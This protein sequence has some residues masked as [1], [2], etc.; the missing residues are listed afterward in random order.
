M[1][2]EAAEGR[3]IN[4]WLVVGNDLQ[5][6]TFQ[7]PEFV[8]ELDGERTRFSAIDEGDWV[9]IV[10]TSGKVERVARI[11]RVRSDLHRT[12]LYFDK[13]AKV[14]TAASLADLS[15]SPPASGAVSRLP[16]ASFTAA[17]PK[18]GIS[19]VHDVPLLQH[20]AYIRELLQLAVIDDLLG[21]AN[22]PHER[23]LD[24]GVRDRYLVGKLAPQERADGGV[25]GL[26]GPLAE[27][28]A[29]DEPDDLEV[30]T[31]RHVPG[32]EFDGT[33]GRVDAEAEASDEIDATNNQ[34]LVPSS[35]G[36]T[37][38]VDGDVKSIVVEARWGRYV[39]SYD[40]GLTKTINRKV[41][42]EDGNVTRTEQTEVALKVWQRE[43]RGGTLTID[44]VTGVVTHRAP[45]SEQ[46]EVRVQGAVRAK[47]ANGDRLVTLFLVNAQIDPPDNKD[48]AWLFQ[49]ELI[50]RAVQGGEESAIFRR[51]APVSA[52]EDEE[53]RALEMI[54]R[55]QVEF[56]VGHG[57]SVHA[58]VAPEN[59]EKATE[60]RTSVV[61]R[62]EV[63]VT[64]T[65]GARPDDRPAMRAMVDQGHLDMDV[66]ATMPREDL[67]KALSVLAGDYGDWIAEQQ[68]RIPK[69]LNGHEDQAKA[70]LA[71][72]TLIKERLEEGIA[73]LAN[74][75]DDKP[76]A[77]FRFANRAMAQQRVHS[78]YAL[79]RR[80]GESRDLASFE[81]RKNRSWRPFQLA[82]MLLSIPALANPAHK[83][84]TES[85]EAIAD[86]LWFP[87]GGGKTEAYLGVAAFAMAIRR[88]QGNLGGY[89]GT[90]GLT[91]IMRY[92]LRL[93]TL[94]Q[95]QRGSTLICAM[96]LM[97]QEAEA[98]GDHSLGKEPFTI[99]LWVGNKVTP[100]TTADSHKAIQDI[101]DPDKYDAGGTSPAQLTSC[102]WCGCG[103]SAKHDVE[104]DTFGKRT[105]IYCGDKKG[106]CSFSKGKSSKKPHPGIPVLVVDEEIYHRPPT[107]MIATVD[108]FALMAWR[109]E[110]RTLFGKATTECPRHGLLWPD[111]DCTGNHPAGKGLPKTTAKT[112]SRIRPPDLI[113]QD[114]F[115]L[116]SGPLGTM[117]GLYE[118]AIDD[119][120]SWKLDG[121]SVK[122]KI[123][124]STATVRK[125][126]EQ[127]NNVFMRRVAVFPP[128]GLDVS[129]NFFSIQRPISMLAGRR[130]IGV[131]SPG[132]SRPAMLIRVYTAFL[133]ASQGLFNRFGQAA[134]PYLTTVGYF[135]SLR[136][137]GGMRRLAEDDVQTRAYRVKMSEVDRPGLEQR[138]VKNIR[139][140]T[141]RVSSRDIPDYL[142]QL[143]I[144]FKAAF[145]PAEGRYVTRW[146]D[147]ETHAIDVVLATNMLSVG[148]DVNRLG[149]MVVNGQPKGTAEYI[150][151]TSRVGRSSPGIVC[152]V[153]TWARPRDLSH[154]ETFEHYHAT[155]YKHVEAQS[156]TPFSPRA[157][158]R[159]LTGTLLSV[160]RLDNAPFNPNP[161]AGALDKPDR[162]EAV[163]ARDLL[164]DRAWNISQEATI[165]DLAMAELKERLDEWATEAGKGGRTLAYEKKG[166]DKATTYPLLRRPGIQAWDNFTVPMSMREVEPGV[167]L[168]MSTARFGGA[169]PGWH[170]QVADDEN[171]GAP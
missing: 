51:R 27:E 19:T 56:A 44:L 7:Y 24:M 38:C 53:R 66:L 130:Y 37:F 23:I 155:F 87:T 95:F 60:V 149:L 92:T 45:D 61:P 150:Q 148:V 30:H 113:I 153:L 10:G 39:R 41:R 114:E 46:P 83:H 9:L 75:G 96:E 166:P 122:P 167:R 36:M 129:D 143:E 158:D 13:L 142:D 97:R 131:C 98:A 125:A 3:A 26:D 106:Q 157:M 171:G 109:G 34:S 25:E 93:L 33:T 115:H 4:A 42:D 47:S 168:I 88:M 2:D 81:Q 79:S 69:E 22:G 162:T 135:N 57:V 48:S 12:T 86:L 151:A 111:A 35:L 18:L 144:K 16:W 59:P 108:K 119:L 164:V 165:R 15:I 73:V 123:V 163:A 72:C 40:H 104:V 28:D 116:I 91:V 154:Y 64:E 141:S 50:V 31:G 89:D 147:G 105:A 76:L 128:H 134:D 133:T 55:Q 145:D 21:P 170:P 78:M 117:V 99:G 80:R 139:E 159:G 6:T 110:V 112:I 85:V 77:A 32:E 67:V 120:C 107:M 52:K 70:A 58:E 84:R 90:R 152:T 43:P 100:G 94:Q 118:T 49:P 54:Y 68:A 121:L 65:P 138:S 137:L 156:V 71:R 14:G 74:T 127:V 124:A 82:F 140:L 62:Y 169:D 102:P 160:M 11:M 8:V 1:S 17:L 146:E 29:D 126:A 63:P 136:E 132:S 5:A 101:R 103:I 20:E 161:G